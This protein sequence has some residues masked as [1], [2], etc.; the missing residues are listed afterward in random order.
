QDIWRK[1]E[2]SMQSDI[3]EL[4]IK[5]L[6]V[7][8]EFNELTRKIIEEQNSH[9]IKE[10]NL[11]KQLKEAHQQVIDFRSDQRRLKELENEIK[12][13][14]SSESGQLKS[15]NKE[16]DGLNEQLAHRNQRVTELE[17]VRTELQQSKQIAENQLF[18]LREKH[19]ALEDDLRKELENQVLKYETQ[20]VELESLR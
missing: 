8:S 3:S 13:L 12:T 15:K 18:E 7:E 2:K 17:K 5:L 9:K 4:N 11:N 14:K 20:I 6:K 16:I 10:D 1:T 19:K